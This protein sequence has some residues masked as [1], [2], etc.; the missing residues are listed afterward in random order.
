MPKRPQ[1]RRK[2]PHRPLNQAALRGI[3]TDEVGPGGLTYQVQRVGPSDKVYVCP[4][5][6]HD[7]GPGI[8]HIVA[9]PTDAPFG[10]ETGVGARRHWHSD[11]WRRGLSPR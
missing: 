2:G 5:C 1:S 6:H 4:G 10:T 3:P 7:V 8:E 11:C 9:W